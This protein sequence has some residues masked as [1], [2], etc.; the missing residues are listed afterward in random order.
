M[1]LPFIMDPL[2]KPH[3]RLPAIKRSPSPTF[4]D[5]MKD[6]VPAPLRRSRSPDPRPRIPDEPKRSQPAQEARIPDE[7]KR[8]QPVQVLRVR[9]DLDS[10]NPRP[11]TAL[12][13]SRSVSP[14]RNFRALEPA[15][16]IKPMQASNTRPRLQHLPA[17]PEYITLEQVRDLRANA[18]RRP[19]SPHQRTL[20]YS[21]S[22]REVVRSPPGMRHQIRLTVTSPGTPPSSRS[23]K[24]VPSM[25]DYLSLEQLEDLWESQD[26]YK[27]PI[28]VPQ[29]PAS[30][31][32][33]IDEDDPRSPIHPAFRADYSIHN[34]FTRPVV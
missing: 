1:S 8:S 34:S 12:A 7:C 33:R 14:V 17:P 32:W 30:P 20:P 26:F 3:T 27:G 11:S 15:P 21:R 16:E 23:R 24:Y 5:S 2:P 6:L 25:A 22:T 13:H 4:L 28:D 19:H 31:M 9:E 10:L 29:K 18:N